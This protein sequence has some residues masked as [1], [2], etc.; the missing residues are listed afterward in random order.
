MN[1]RAPTD[2]VLDVVR[3]RADLL[4][5][6]IEG[7]FQKPALVSELDVSR[8]TVD[9]ATR[10][11]ES[12]GLVT[13]TDGGLR[14]T[15]AGRVVYEE[16]RR[17]VPRIE[18]VIDA[19]DLLDSLP[20]DA[21]LAPDLLVGGSVVVADEVAPQVPG[22]K[23]AELFADADRCDALARAHSHASAVPVIE[24]RVLSDGM[25][26]SV[27]AERRFLEY[28]RSDLSEF[29]ARLVDA[30]QVQLW[31]VSDVPYGLFLFERGD[32]TTACML[33]YD[34]DN[35]LRGVVVND[36]PDA[37]A[38]TRDEVRAYRERAVR[39]DR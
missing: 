2:E 16:Y 37:V 20:A 39:V 14:T 6:L 31:A 7:P 13:Y 38:W 1:P 23:I 10:R 5:V 12:L 26:L 4:E 30:E 22:S 11:L 15:T 9:R 36:S 35:V 19:R 24:D 17:V 8:S 34:V 21:D 28:L 33:V 18:S 25:E 32:R 27:V 3:R 29:F